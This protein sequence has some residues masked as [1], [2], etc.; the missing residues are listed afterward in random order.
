MTF[1]LGLALGFALMGFVKNATQDSKIEALE[2][3]ID[4]LILTV[5]EANQ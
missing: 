3:R 2:K 4:V 1:L 5:Q